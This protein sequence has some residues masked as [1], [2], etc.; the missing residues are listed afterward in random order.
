MQKV[1]IQC[2]ALL[3]CVA[4]WYFCAESGLSLCSL[5]CILYLCGIG[6][7]RVAS[8]CVACCLMCSFVVLECIEC[9]VNIYL[10]VYC[11]AL[12]FWRVESCLSVCI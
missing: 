8:Q 12:F 2:V 6:F 10:A 7:Q 9:S 5:Q 11:V 1:A 4:F 3:Y